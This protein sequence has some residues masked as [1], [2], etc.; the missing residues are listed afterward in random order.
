MS[1]SAAADSGSNP[2]AAGAADASNSSSSSS[3]S[4]SSTTTATS[5]LLDIDL[6]SPAFCVDVDV[7]RANCTKMIA[8]AAK[9]GL[10]LRP[11]VKTHKT[12]EGAAL[13]TSHV[14][15][16]EAKVVVSTLREAEFLAEKGFGD[17]L[18]GVP[19]EPSKFPRI[20]SLH[21]SLP[22]FH[23]MLDSFEALEALEGYA[24]RRISSASDE[25]RK[26][27]EF[28]QST[29]R[30]SVFLAVDASGYKR[31]GVLPESEAAV[32][33]GVAIAKSRRVKLTGIYSHSGNSYCAS[34]AAAGGEGGSS[35]CPVPAGIDAA[36]RAGAAAIACL[37]RDSMVAFAARLREVAGIEVP[38]ISL[39]ATPSACSAIHWAPGLELHPGNYLFFD[40]QQ[41]ESGSC[42]Y[43]DIAVYV[44]A[45]VIARYPERG[46]FL[47]DAGSCAMHKDPAGMRDGFWGALKDDPSLVLRKMTQEVAVVGPAPG[48]PP[49]DFASSRYALGAVVRVLPN[50]ACMTAACHALYHA[51]EGPVVP[52]EEVVGGAR[53][54]VGQWTPCKFW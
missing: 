18:Y 31:E 13:Q 25:E 9:Q 6:P 11:H 4:S 1:S 21:S 36:G 16:S 19:L 45:R 46:E 2:R 30:I 41:H 34:A 12:E 33:L 44:L 35:C 43:A 38:V 48:A 3:T 24:G 51:V 14:D 5:T 37:E 29:R 10:G 39:G 54:V 8:V 15:R 26:S 28:L 53:K 23:V 49:V 17:I 47:I 50:H 32:S 20:W 7:V 27:D 22:S 40:R 42:A 52:A